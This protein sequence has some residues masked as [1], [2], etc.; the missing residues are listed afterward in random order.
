MSR[1]FIDAL[2]S[3]TPLFGVLITALIALL[4]WYTGKK[5]DAEQRFLESRRPFVELRQRLY[6]EA[7]RAAEVLATPEA[8]TPEES[9]AAKKRFWELYWGE[10]SLVETTDVEEAMVQ[11]GKVFDPN[12][13]VR[14]T[15]A[16]EKTYELAH[17]LSNSLKASWGIGTD[18]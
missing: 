18:D 5:R 14:L 11:L 3:A 1:E 7:I 4:T 12:V 16:Q 10:L 2:L 13:K 17:V 15:E 8:H 6:L 9:T